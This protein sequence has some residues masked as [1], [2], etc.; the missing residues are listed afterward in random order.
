MTEKSVKTVC[1]VSL[2][3]G[4]IGE[5]YVSH[6]VEIGIRRLLDYGI[7]VRFSEH[8]RMGIDYIKNNPESR[9]SDLLSA[10]Y[11]PE[12]DMILCAIGG[13]DTYRLLPYLFDD[14]KLEKNISRF[15]GYDD[16]PSDVLQDWTEYVLWTGISSGFMRNRTSDACLQPQVF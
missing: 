8:A 9:A 2:S 16:Q 7:D 4:I 15:F 1:I 3:S 5:P 6:E 13:D 14:C 10:L 11:D 12:I